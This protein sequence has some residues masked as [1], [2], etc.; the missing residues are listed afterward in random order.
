MPIPFAAKPP[1]GGHLIGQPFTI[2][3]LSI[4][5]NCLFTCNC[6]PGNAAMPIVASAPVTCATCAKTYGVV[7]N[8]A[9]NQIQV[10]MVDLTAQ[11]PS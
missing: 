8:P 9:N 6:Q 7:F 1:M 2:T 5:V 10:Q 3:D 4:P 11:V